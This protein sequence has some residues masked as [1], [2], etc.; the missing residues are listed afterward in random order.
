MIPC[1]IPKLS[2]LKLKPFSS[3]SL[4]KTPLESP[5]STT[6]LASPLT[7]HF[8]EQSARSSQ[9]HFIKQ[10]ESSLT[11]SLISQTLLNL[12]ESP[13]VVLDFLNH[14][15]HKLSDART[16]CLAIVIVA[17]LPSPKPALHL[18]KQ[19][20]GG[21][22]TNSIREIFEFL[23]A[24]RDRLGFK[25]SIVFDYLIKSCCDMNRADE[26]FECFYTMKEKGVLPTIE[27]CNSLL[28]LFLKLN[29]T[30]AAWVLYAEM[31]RLRIKSSV[32]T[33]NIMINV[34]CKE[35]KLKKAK[36]FVGHMET[37]GVKPN[38]VTYN[39]IVHGYCSSGRWDVQARKT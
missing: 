15:H 19:A 9:W 29:R 11:P 27:T 14:F 36:D 13:Q 37:S 16:L 2:S 24:S 10:V 25:S 18:L 38:I 1:R 23:A 30:E 6:N 39:T 35:G 4:Q 20:L 7:P 34:L 26:A 22:T 32:Y 33:F 3:I 17:R 31:F 5:V 28:S 21:G 12:H 8:L